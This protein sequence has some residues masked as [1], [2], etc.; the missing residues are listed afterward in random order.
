[1]RAVV[2]SLPIHQFGA[3]RLRKRFRIRD[4]QVREHRP[5]KE[6]CEISDRPAGLDCQ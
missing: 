2:M 6:P 1:M 3:A 4:E 5:Y